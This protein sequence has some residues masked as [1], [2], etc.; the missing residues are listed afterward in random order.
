LTKE[1]TEEHIA[2]AEEF[3]DFLTRAFE[4]VFHEFWSSMLDKSSISDTSLYNNWVEELKSLVDS[5]EELAKVNK[6]STI[7]SNYIA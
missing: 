4:L 6:F 5:E 7:L 1:I 2:E 3:R